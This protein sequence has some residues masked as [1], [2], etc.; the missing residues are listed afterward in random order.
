MWAAQMCRIAAGVLRQKREAE[1]DSGRQS[2]R[3]MTPQRC[4][5]SQHYGVSQLEAPH[6]ERKPPLQL[7][8][9]SPGLRPNIAV[10]NESALFLE[11]CGRILSLKLYQ[12]L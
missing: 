3:H 7:L 12:I 2:W 5:H 6:S 9:L 10:F 11:K 8:I 1:T 4:Y